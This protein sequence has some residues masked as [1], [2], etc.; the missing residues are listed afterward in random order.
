MDYSK[1]SKI[2]I[3]IHYTI[4]IALKIANQTH[5]ISPHTHC[6]L[7]ARHLFIWTK[8]VSQK[9]KQN[10]NLQMYKLFYWIAHV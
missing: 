5:F 10:N 7:V 8:I 4:I 3:Q 2:H 9:N 1:Q 6:N